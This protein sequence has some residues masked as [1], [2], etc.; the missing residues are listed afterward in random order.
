[1]AP[2]KISFT[3]ELLLAQKTATGIEVPTHVV[4]QLGTSK[5]PPV[6]VTI[7]GHTYRSTVAVMGGA[8]MLPVNAD[9]REKAGIKAGD[10][11][12]IT[13]EADTQPRVVEV[14]ADFRAALDANPIAAQFFEGLSNSNKKFYI[15]SIEQA[16]TAETRTRRIEKAVADLQLQKKI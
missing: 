1:M 15:G 11:I 4:E 6:K 3:T 8:F 9:V 16:K 13:L 2:E 5:R 12:E 14:P 7:N 10:I